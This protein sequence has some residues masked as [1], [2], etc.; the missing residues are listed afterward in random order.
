MRLCLARTI[1]IR[2][3]ASR[4]LTSARCSRVRPWHRSM[5]LSMATAPP[6]PPGA[7]LSR[8]S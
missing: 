8:A 3:R 4:T 2:A 1:D 7:Q 5:A 6:F